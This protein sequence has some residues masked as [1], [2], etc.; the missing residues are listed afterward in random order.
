MRTRHRSAA[1]RG[2]TLL[3][4]IVAVAILAILAGAA[5]PVTAKAL[6]YK[7]RQAT[8]QEIGLLG[9]AAGEYFR[10]TGALP[11]TVGDLLVDPGAPGWSG[12]YLPGVVADQLSGQ[13]GY[14][15]DAWSR[16][17]RVTTSGDTITLAS[18]GD[19]ADFGGQDDIELAIDVTWIRR[20]TTLE[21]LLVINQAIVLYNGQHQLSD[22]L[23][24]NW[25]VALDKLVARGFLPGPE[26]LRVDGWGDPFVETPRG[27][28][29]VVRVDSPHL[30]GA[31]PA[32]AG[33]GAGSKSKGKGRGKNSSS[34]GKGR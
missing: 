8:R 20:E 15:V 14:A 28:A 19:D 31:L 2:F 29:P 30:S 7:A 4:L 1:R 21:Q 26:G 22:P 23:P 10:D 12:P 16:P 3:E 17:Y 6:A 18:A 32:V 34:K 27:S 11:A 24:A 5:I 25:P 33:G 9:E 13:V